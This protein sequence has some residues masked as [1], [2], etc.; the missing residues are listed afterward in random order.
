MGLVY[1]FIITVIG[2]SRNLEDKVRERE[3]LVVVTHSLV[4]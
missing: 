3:I 2:Q 1:V 4:S